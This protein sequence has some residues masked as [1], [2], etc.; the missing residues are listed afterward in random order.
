MRTWVGVALAWL[1]GCQATLREGLSEEQANQIAVALD[2]AGIAST[3]EGARAGQQPSSF[4][5]RVA[6]DDVGRALRALEHA[7]V[8]RSEPSGFDALLAEPGLLMTPREERARWAAA[9]SGE[10]ARSLERLP[11][12]VDARVHLALA[13]APLALDQPPAPHKASVL[14]RR[15][16]QAAQLS[17]AQ[18]R[19]LVAGGVEGLAPDQVSVI[20][21]SLPAGPRAT[22]RL[23]RVGPIEVTS[24]S[25]GALRAVLG[26]ALSLDLVLAGA[27]IALVHRRRVRTAVEAQT[28][29]PA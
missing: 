26:T 7:E 25:V 27:L 23:V 24:R 5:V 21:S 12:I 1:M 4:G 16:A 14:L 2:E 6:H 9:T 19:A 28:K 18:V 11:G 13:E 15:R 8:P 10:L 17:E 20:Q 22:P 29:A 3:K